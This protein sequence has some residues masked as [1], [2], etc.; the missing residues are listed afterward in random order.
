M[1]SEKQEVIRAQLQM[2]LTFG[3]I[4]FEFWIDLAFFRAIF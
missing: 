3:A 2:L 4:N 1:F